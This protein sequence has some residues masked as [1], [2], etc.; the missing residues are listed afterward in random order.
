MV[1]LELDATTTTGR[2]LLCDW[3]IM[4][5]II[6]SM[7]DEYVSIDPETLTNKQY[8]CLS[9]NVK[10]FNDLWT[11]LPPSPPDS[12][13][14]EATLKCTMKNRV[15]TYKQLFDDPWTMFEFLYKNFIQ[16]LLQLNGFEALVREVVNDE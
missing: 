8:L 9:N 12:V 11:K 15:Q 5:H 7:K 14:D 2:N 1:H 10:Y 3:K 13:F 16:N 4:N 6:T